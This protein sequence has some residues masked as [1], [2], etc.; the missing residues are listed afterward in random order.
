MLSRLTKKLPILHWL[1]RYNKKWLRADFIAGVSVWAL[2]VPEALAYAGIAGVPPAYGLYTAA[3]A[4][5]LFGIS[6]SSRHV[7]TG[8]SSTVAAVTGAVV[9]SM[10]AYGS[11]E[12]V[13]LAAAT[14]LLA[15]AFFLILGFLRLG[16]I[17]NFL[18]ASVLTG[19]I[20]GLAIDI[21]VGQGEHLV[22]YA[23]EGD[24]AW[25]QIGDIFSG[26]S[27]LS[28]LTLAVGGIALV[29]LF[30]LKKYAHKAPG[31]LITVVL[32]I[33]AAGL[34]NL[35]DQGV[36]LVGNVPRGLPSVGLPAISFSDLATLVPA[37]LGIVL[38]GFSESIG[39]AR[40]YASKHDYD[41]DPDQEMIALGLA[42]GSGFF[43]G[44]AVD[45][46][47][48][49]SAA[50]DNAGGKTQMASLIQ[51]GFIILTMLFLAPIFAILP[52]AVLGA[53]VIEAVVGLMNVKEMKRLYRIERSEF[54]LGM[55]ALLGVVTFG[56]IPGILIGVTLS[57]LLLI[58]RVS[59]PDIPV[60]GKKPERDVY[61]S[62]DEHPD[63][64]TYPG[65]AIIRFDGPLYFATINAL[66]DR[67]KKLT[68]GVEPLVKWLVFDMEAV[69]FVDLEGADMLKAIIEKMKKEGIEFHLA[70]VRQPVLDFLK[71]A[72]LSELLG[73]ENVHADV[74]GAVAAFK[75][76]TQHPD[77]A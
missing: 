35:G 21:A 27:Q 6:S 46:S 31:A 71:E 59:Y 40:I 26:L 25:Q 55:A 17:S 43:Q 18:A 34:F 53:I 64:E 51:A 66:S 1:P 2:M 22:G 4:L 19:F 50:N 58:A 73:D 41:I 16:W 7:I 28:S 67:V 44:F 38:I 62:V 23:V 45:G 61:Q 76:R 69:N 11:N 29:I 36:S 48:S 33:L 3:A 9:L 57:L 52:E 20:F 39:A 37:A 8:P 47:L 74:E 70:R 24:N 54:W 13:Q 42:N 14:A 65:L 5:I 32:G 15:G 77:A 10:A 49:K 63:S 75:K 60:L 68:T 72:D 56:T 12:A 30:G